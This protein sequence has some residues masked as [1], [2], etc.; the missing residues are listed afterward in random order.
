M[1]PSFERYR[2]RCTHEVRVGRIV[3]AVDGRVLTENRPAGAGRAARRT[4]T[5]RNLER[6]EQPR[7][8]PVYIDRREPVFTWQIDRDAVIGDQPLQRNVKS[9]QSFV[10]TKRVSQ[11]ILQGSD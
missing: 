6:A 11:F 5:I 7:V 10:Q 3:D 8:G 9:G 2:K 1:P 4:L